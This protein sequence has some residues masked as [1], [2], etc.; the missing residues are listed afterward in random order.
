MCTHRCS[1]CGRPL[2]TQESIE[3]GMGERC[4]EK[5]RATPNVTASTP[6]PTTGQPSSTV[7]AFETG[8][9]PLTQHRVRGMGRDEHRKRIEA[10]MIALADRQ[11]LLPWGER[12]STKP[13]RQ[14]RRKA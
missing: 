1:K 14:R 13:K 4:A 2:H 5:A 11:T 12:P 7:T 8:S 3:R 9:P 6:P 10:S